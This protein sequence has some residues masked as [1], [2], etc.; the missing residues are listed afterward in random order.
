MSRATPWR[1]FIC[2]TA[3]ARCSVTPLPEGEGFLIW[4]PHLSFSTIPRGENQYETFCLC[5]VRSCH[6][7]L[8]FR[9]FGL[10]SPFFRRDVF[11]RSDSK[12][13]R[14]SRSISLPQSTLFPARG[15]SR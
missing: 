10:R 9:G 8:P 1:A 15:S 2:E 3:V 7:I 6:C 14:E 11:G 13:R 5:S 12:N 4:P